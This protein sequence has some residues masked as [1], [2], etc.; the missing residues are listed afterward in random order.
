[1]QE[2]EKRRHA[3]R[4][5]VV[6]RNGAPLGPCRVQRAR[7]L[8]RS[9]RARLYKPEPYTIQL[10]DVQ[11]ADLDTSGLKTEVRVNPGR[12]HTGIAVVMLLE[13]EDRVV[14]QEELQ[15]RTGHQQKAGPTGKT[16][17][18]TAAR[19]MAP[20]TAVQQPQTDPD[21]LP[22][23]ME[24]VVSNQQT[25]AERLA[26]AAGTKNITIETARFDTAKILNPRI[27]GTKYQQGPR[28]KTH[29][30]A[31]IAA[32]DKHKCVYCGLGDWKKTGRFEID[33]VV[34]RAAGGTDNPGNLA[35][36]CRPCN[37]QRGSRSAS[38]FLSGKPKRLT[39]VL[40]R[41]QPP[42]ACAGQ[43]AWLC[44]ALVER[45]RRNGFKVSETTGAD[46]AANRK[47]FGIKKTH[48][49]DAACA[50]AVSKVTELR[51]QVTLSAVGH[52]RR[53]QV[54]GT[55]HRGVPRMAAP[56]ADCEK[57]S[58]SPVPRRFTTYR[59]R[60]KDRRSNKAKDKARHRRGPGRS[61]GSSRKDRHQDEGRPTSI[62]YRCTT[63]NT[64]KRRE[65]LDEESKV[66][67][68]PA[69]T[70]RA[71]WTVGMGGSDHHRMEERENARQE[72]D[73]AHQRT[74]AFRNCPNQ[75]TQC[76]AER[77][78][79]SPHGRTQGLRAMDA[80]ANKV[81]EIDERLEAITAELE[82]TGGDPEGSSTGRE[83]RT[84]AR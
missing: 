4:C 50:G 67:H 66:D 58:T 84:T 26:E 16:P 23:S 45:L 13:G 18:K 60:N 47:E 70:T 3:N 68:C 80:V 65:R 22:P 42:L 49:N 19:K 82:R 24:S 40:K 83:D 2:Q 32:R 15:H 57:K 64:D 72:D 39:A 76:S 31:Y 61:P 17:Q 35:W 28:Y 21:Q 63:R 27:R 74:S 48:A 10:K 73:L 36:A 14:Y 20:G 9:G 37:K 12:R 30:R 33:H 54:K 59:R 6:D 52:G 44:K 11:A 25:R 38:A 29:L 62:D 5:F 69:I 1:M 46:T 55:T 43:Q 75:P 79:G 53:K 8:R 56:T 71:L 77:E 51:K 41:K 78:S 81:N 34:P 7:K